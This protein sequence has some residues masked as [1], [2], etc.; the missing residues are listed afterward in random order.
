VRIQK[1]RLPITTNPIEK[2]EEVITEDEQRGT[3]MGLE[4]VVKSKILSHF[5]KRKIALTPMETIR[6]I[7]RKL[8]YLVGLVKLAR[9]RKDVEGQK[10]Q[11]VS[12]HST[13]AIKKVSVNKM[14]YN[15][16]LH[17][18]VEINQGMI[19][20]LVDTRASMSVM[21]TDVVKELGIM[22]L[23]AGHEIYKTTFSIVMQALGRITELL[24]KV[25]GIMCQM[26]FLL[27]T[28]TTMI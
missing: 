23:V 7:P 16:T 18:V 12:I 5:I 6:I 25:E 13:F 22:H 28:Q 1:R 17:L 14:H 27:W 15:K 20:G 11:V 19:E 10:N 4:A 3:N 24:V 21:A 26:I 2:Q 8:E 9:R